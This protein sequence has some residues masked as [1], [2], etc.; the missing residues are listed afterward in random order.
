MGIHIDKHIK[1]T[2]IQIFLHVLTF[3][4]LF[5]QIRAQIENCFQW[6]S[7][8]VQLLEQHI[9][10]GEEKPFTI[11]NKNLEN[12]DV[13]EIEEYFNAY[14]DKYVQKVAKSKKMSNVQKVCNNYMY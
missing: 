8:E 7:D 3:P 13:P 11:N 6:A 14:L 10:S 4:C 9:K 1:G 12:K 2:H 5:F